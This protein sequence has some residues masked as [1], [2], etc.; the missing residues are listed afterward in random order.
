MWPPDPGTVA[1]LYVHHP[2]T[3]MG[4]PAGALRWLQGHVA[5]PRSCCSP[6]SG[7]RA[8]GQCAS[9]IHFPGGRALSWVLAWIYPVP[10]QGS[11]V[12]SWRK[13]MW[14]GLPSPYAH[15]LSLLGTAPHRRKG[16][17]FPGG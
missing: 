9:R 13:R 5:G 7:W 10:P 15:P 6:C 2:Q 4:E 3:G 8:R 12:P 14:V 1:S 11:E 17:D 16:L